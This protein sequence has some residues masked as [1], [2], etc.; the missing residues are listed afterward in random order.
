MQTLAEVRTDFIDNY[1]K[2]LRDLLE[3]LGENYRPTPDRIPQIVD[4]SV[5]LLK[6]DDL[7]ASQFL[8]SSDIRPLGWF[9]DIGKE[10]C[11]LAHIAIAAATFAAWV[12]SGGT[13][14]VGTVV[15]GVTITNGIIAA[16]VGG[17]SGRAL[18]EV[19]C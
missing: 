12:A 15:V 14:I 10:A 16:L 8:G 5:A 18:A 19:F 11:I 7:L 6:V 1:C 2:E 17:A 3:K 4:N 9:P 13:L